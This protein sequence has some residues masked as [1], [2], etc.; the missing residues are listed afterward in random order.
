[1]K[2]Q[3]MKLISF[4]C[5]MLLVG[6]ASSQEG[7]RLLA[8]KNLLNEY[9][10]EGKDISVLYTIYNVGSSAAL[11]VVLSDKTF[12]DSHF[13]PV[14]GKLTVQWERISPGNNVT[15]SVILQSVNSGFFNFTSATVT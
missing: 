1:L 13:R 8:A 9:L 14:L 11:N 7:A 12:P 3:K 6:V 5:V 10:V 15:H 2:S 4:L